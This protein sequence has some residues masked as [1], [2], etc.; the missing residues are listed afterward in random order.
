LLGWL[1]GMT[2]GTVLAE[3]MQLKPVYPLQFAGQTYTVYIG[4]IALSANVVVSFA[5]S[6]ILTVAGAKPA[7]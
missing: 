7:S 6:W 4:L 3:S 2:I 5:A 1:A